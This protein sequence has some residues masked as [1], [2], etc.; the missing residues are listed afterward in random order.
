MVKFGVASSL[1]PSFALG[2]GSVSRVVCFYVSLEIDEHRVVSR[3]VD[4]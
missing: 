1:V 4:R 2:V 3:G